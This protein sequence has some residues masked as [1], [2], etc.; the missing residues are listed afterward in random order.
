[1]NNGIHFGVSREEYDRLGRVNWSNLKLMAKS[2]A[3][4]RFN[5]LKKRAGTDAMKVGRATHVAVFEPEAF[6]ST[7]VL[8]D[9]GTRR[10]KEWDKFKAAHEGREIL[11]EVEHE[12]CVAIGAAVRADA[13]AAQYLAGGKSELTILWTHTVPAVGQL[14][15][16]SIDAKARVDFA[17]DVGA[18]VDLKT[19]RDASPEGFGRDS[20]RLGYHAQA[21]IYSDAYFAVTGRRLPYVLVAVESEAPYAVQTYRVP[22]IALELGREHYRGLMDRLALCRSENR[23]PAYGDGE[24][25]L[26]LPRWAM[27]FDEDEDVTGMDLVVHNQE[28][29]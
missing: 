20:W 18:L 25:E 4:Y 23:W 19:T 10:G 15:G 24:M 9:G 11:T 2:P 14:P 27:P 7:C 13:T 6:A 1:M 3:H 29:V 22:D 8:W 21:A 28:A 26:N 16:Y 17:A 12:K 5:Q